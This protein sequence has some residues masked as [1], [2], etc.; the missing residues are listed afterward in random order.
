MDPVR[1]VAVGDVCLGDHVLNLGRGT[2]S[3]MARRSGPYPF[4]GVVSHLS[5]ADLCMGNLEGPLSLV[6][7][8]PARPLTQWMRGS[9]AA[10]ATLSAAGFGIL[11][12]ANNHM[13][14]Y[15]AQAFQETIDGLEKAGISCIGLR[16]GGG[17]QPLI[18]EVQNSRIGFLAYSFVPERHH[19]DPRPYAIGSPAVVRADLL[20][21]RPK[22]DFVVVACHWGVELMDRPPA[23]TIVMARSLIDWGADVVLGHH[24]HVFQAVE[25][26]SRGVIAY[27]LGN[28]V[29]DA[30][31]DEPCRRSAI[32]N[33]TLGR[34][35]QGTEITW[36]VTPI[37]I[38][39]DFRPIPLSDAPAAAFRRTLEEISQSRYYDVFG[40]GSPS[41]LQEYQTELAHLEGRSQR[42]KLLYLA[43][44]AL[45][46]DRRV[47]QALLDKGRQRVGLA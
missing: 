44:H 11:S 33:L 13:A 9:P 43:R 6:G 25:R 38:A 24:P 47:L 4:D 2:R 40:E 36:D 32:L 22:V 7:E 5:N 42:R 45:S 46:T 15:G 23:D 3:L 37:R 8:D 29:F 41:R 14:Q 18:R 1:I 10:I 35:L 30:V 19:P 17:C 28:F 27:S 39:D 34:T 20:D 12:V 21:L 26:R 16:S 31:W